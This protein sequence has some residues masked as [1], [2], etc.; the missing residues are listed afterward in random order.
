[1]VPPEELDWKLW[2]DRWDRMQERYITRRDERFETIVRL[3]GETQA[4]VDAVLDL[5]CGTGSL[6]LSVLE[7][8]P[9]AVVYGIDFDPTILWLAQARLKPFGKRARVILADLRDVSWMKAVQ[10]PFDAAVSATALH[11]FSPDQL[12][13]L[14]GQISGMLA[15][16]GIFLNADHAGSSSPAIQQE[17]ERQRR[18][19][20]DREADFNSDTWEGFWEEYGKALGTDISE[21]SRRVIGGWEN[22]IE[23]GL[24]LQWHF[25]RLHEK[26][27][28]SVDCFWRCDYDA[29]YGGIKK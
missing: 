22:G 13:I 28:A 29:I 19:I 23:E 12:S 9:G 21:S 4:S 7:A 25:Q 6:M 24:P 2:V 15:S 16:G 14:Y 17:W 8:F 3:V 5:G 27:F 18:E 11:W 20:L 1:M 10:P 26:G